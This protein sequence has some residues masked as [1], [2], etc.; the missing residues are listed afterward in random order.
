MSPWD[1]DSA[2]RFAQAVM[3]AC[4]WLELTHEAA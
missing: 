2:A 3:D 4:E 1:A